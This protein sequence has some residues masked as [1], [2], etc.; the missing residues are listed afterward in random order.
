[1]GRERIQLLYAPVIVRVAP[2]RDHQNLYNLW[3]NALQAR[4]IKAACG[5]RGRERIYDEGTWENK[6]SIG[7][8]WTASK[9]SAFSATLFT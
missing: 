9:Y 4:K 8:T 1:M 5:C 3:V 6:V 7:P 2:Q